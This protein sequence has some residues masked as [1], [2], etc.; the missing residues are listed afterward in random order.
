MAWTR[1]WL[2]LTATIGCSQ[3]SRP[4]PGF[5]VAQRRTARASTETR[6]APVLVLGIEINEIPADLFHHRHSCSSGAAK[7]PVQSA[8]NH[9]FVFGPN[10]LERKCLESMT[11]SVSL[12]SEARQSDLPDAPEQS[13]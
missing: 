13:G 9:S 8:I 11:V 12:L 7:Q 6:A 5:A 10:R 3:S 2:T 1:W 4:W